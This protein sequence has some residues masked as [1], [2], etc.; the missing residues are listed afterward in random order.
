MN[1]QYVY[2][3]PAILRLATSRPTSSYS[4]FRPVSRLRPVFISPPLSPSFFRLVFLFPQCL[5]LVAV[6]SLSSLR[7]SHVSISSFFRLISSLLRLCPSRLCLCLVYVS[8]TSLP[9]LP[10]SRPSVSPYIERSEGIAAGQ[11]RYPG[12]ASGGQH[13]KMARAISE[14]LREFI[15]SGSSY[16]SCGNGMR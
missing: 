1:L 12:R 14:H 11:T 15:D 6:L 5:C 4:C 3:S 7:L 8:S 10:P 2:P 16:G 13:W 9:V